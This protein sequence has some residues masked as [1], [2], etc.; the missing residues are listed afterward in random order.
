MQCITLQT[1]PKSASPPFYVA[2]LCDSSCEPRPDGLQDASGTRFSMKMMIFEH[3]FGARNCKKKTEAS[4]FSGIDILALDNQYASVI[5]VLGPT[6]E[7]FWAPTTA[8]LGVIL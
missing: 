1:Q 7:A 8:Y 5:R 6:W 4:R 2:F 3:Q